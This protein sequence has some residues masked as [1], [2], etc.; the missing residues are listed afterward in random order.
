MFYALEVQIHDI[1]LAKQ[2]EYNSHCRLNL[3]KK[4][5][6]IYKIKTYFFDEHYN[7][8]CC[9]LCTLVSVIF[10]SILVTQKSF[11]KA[12]TAF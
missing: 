11:F 10:G 2:Q 9:F 6:L 5:N 12:F 8:K 4:K 3:P 7:K 1:N